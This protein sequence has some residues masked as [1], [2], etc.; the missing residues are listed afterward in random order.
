M[1]FI[2]VNIHPSLRMIRHPSG[3]HRGESL[4]GAPLLPSS[5]S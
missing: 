2:H 1:I 5:L 3:L 4:L